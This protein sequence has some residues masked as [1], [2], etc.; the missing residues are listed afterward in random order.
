MC[1]TPKPAIQGFLFTKA[2][3]QFLEAAR[4]MDKTD[5]SVER[6][7]QTGSLGVLQE[8]PLHFDTSQNAIAIGR[9]LVKAADN[10]VF[11]IT[12]YITPPGLPLKK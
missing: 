3:P 7:Q 9:L 10:T 4:Q 5:F 2:G 12:A 8:Q 11:D 1:T 6:L